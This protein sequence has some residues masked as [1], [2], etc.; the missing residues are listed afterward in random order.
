MHTQ[1]QRVRCIQAVARCSS[2]SHSLCQRSEAADGGGRETAAPRQRAGERGSSARMGDA[3]NERVAS[4][5]AAAERL[6]LTFF[7]FSNE[8]QQATLA[9]LVCHESQ[10]A[11]RAHQRMRQRS[12]VSRRHC[13][14]LE[15][16]SPHRQLDRRIESAFCAAMP[17]CALESTD[18]HQ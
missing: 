10:R 18:V 6:S 4:G 12:S 2:V 1:M 3:W 7:C 15:I 13:S 14:S 11:C 5:T 17:C 9:G 16:R 8:L